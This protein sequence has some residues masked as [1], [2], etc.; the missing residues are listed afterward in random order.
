MAYRN[1]IEN[2]IDARVIGKLI[3]LGSSAVCLRREPSTPREGEL[4]LSI[5]FGHKPGD[6]GRFHM[7]VYADGR[8]IWWCYCVNRS[9]EGI[10]NGILERRLT[11]DGLELVRSEVLSTGLF[12][13]DLYLESAHGLFGGW[14]EILDEEG[15]VRLSWQTDSQVWPPEGVAPV[16]PSAEQVS[17]LVRLDARLEDLASWLPATAWVDEEARPYVPSS[18]QIC[19]RTEGGGFER[20][21]VLDSL[22]PACPGPAPSAGPVP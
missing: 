16:T 11:S 7:E 8:V 12:D 5:A 14:I 21:E 22:P 6:A 4:V 19:Y 10:I 3:R 18:Y 15:S 1:S 20:D 13:H 2:G 17:A 9:S